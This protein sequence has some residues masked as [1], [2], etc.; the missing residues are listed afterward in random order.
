MSPLVPWFSRR[1]GS[2][3]TT[4]IVGLV[5]SAAGLAGFASAADVAAWTAWRVVQGVGCA[6]VDVPA[7]GLVRAAG[8]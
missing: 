8:T 7:M 3:V 2:R 4:L 5:V 1:V 6:L